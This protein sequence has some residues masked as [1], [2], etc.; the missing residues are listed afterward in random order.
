MLTLKS[1]TSAKLI[2]ISA[3]MSEVAATRS[4]PKHPGNGDLLLNPGLLTSLYLL[5]VTTIIL[6]TAGVHTW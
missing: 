4:L 1:T 3:A 2:H 6:Q 5:A